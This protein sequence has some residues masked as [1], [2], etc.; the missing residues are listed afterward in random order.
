MMCDVRLIFLGNNKFGEIKCTPEVL[1]SLPKPKPSN[2]EENPCALAS[3]SEE[4]VVGILDESNSS[5]TL[6]CLPCSLDT[7][8]MELAKQDTSLKL[9]GESNNIALPVETSCV[10]TA[11]GNKLTPQIAPTSNSGVQTRKTS[12]PNIDQIT[13]GTPPAVNEAKLERTVETQS[14]TNQQETEN[15]VTPA[16]KN[17]YDRPISSTEMDV[18]PSEPEI[19][20]IHDDEPVQ[21]TTNKLNKR[22]VIPEPMEQPNLTYN[23]RNKELSNEKQE[24]VSATKQTTNIKMCTVRLEIL[25]EADIVKHVHVHKEIESK[26]APPVKPKELVGTVE[27]VETVHLT[28][29]HTKNKTPRTNRLPRIAS[30]NVAYVHQDELSD[31]GSSPSPIRKRILRPKR[32]P[33]STCIKAVSFSTKSPSIRPLRRSSRTAITQSPSANQVPTT[34]GTSNLTTGNPV[35]TAASSD[36]R[37]AAKGSFTTQSFH[38]KR[39]KKTRKIGCKLCDTVCTSNKELTQHHQLKH[40]ILYCDQCSK[41]FNNPS[42]LAKHQYSHKELRFKCTDCNEAFAFESNL[43]THRISHRTL[44]THCCAYANCKKRFKNKGDLTR[45]VKEHDGVIHE[46][47]DCPYK[48]LDIRNLASHRLTHTDI[49][50]YVCDLCH[51]TFRFST[52]KRRHLKDKKCPKLSNSP[53]H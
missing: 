11:N 34:S 6:V 39:S 35:S 43:K 9:E 24:T 8:N 33:S 19:K 53:E 42:S 45:H 21:D 12:L 16:G 15:P 51:K 29:S 5:C 30:K 32:E 2:E 20:D 46:C 4:L 49:E 40:N 13:V 38:L 44:A 17:Q 25:T 14:L 37:N 7:E 27:T 18:E 3:P 48:N 23:K 28:R 31:S 50:K 10:N 41:A 36:A 47:P 26:T 52:Q 22:K 1:S